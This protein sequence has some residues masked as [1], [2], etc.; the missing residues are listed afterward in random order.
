MSQKKEER[1]QRKRRSLSYSAVNHPPVCLE[2]HRGTEVLVLVPPITRAGGAAAGA[3]DAL[4]EPIELITICGGL[5]VLLGGV[6]GPVLLLEE[7]LD[8]LVL[9]I[10]LGEI[11]D[12]I[13]DDIH[14]RQGVDL[15]RG[16][17]ALNL[18]SAGEGVGS[19]NIHG[20]GATDS[21]TT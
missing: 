6:L 9:L 15:R 3:E 10:E 19:F 2:E 8:G 18:A 5:V 1:G 13:L 21:F 12:E 20:A 7:G 17:I 16:G 11:G 14:V 4:V